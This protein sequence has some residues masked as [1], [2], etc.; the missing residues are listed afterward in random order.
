MTMI[1]Q[2]MLSP[3]DIVAMAMEQTIVAKSAIVFV[4]T[5]A[6]SIQIF[7]SVPPV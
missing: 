6:P 7:H 4:K 3:G 2:F 5:T 1:V